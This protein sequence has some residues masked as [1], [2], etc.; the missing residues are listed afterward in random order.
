MDCSG[1]W[2]LS[3]WPRTRLRKSVTENLASYTKHCDAP[4]VASVP[5]ITFPL[6]EDDYDDSYNDCHGN[7]D[8]ED[9]VN[10]D[11]NIINNIDNDNNCR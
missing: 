3:T 11:N 5:L 4:E 6:P 8:E 2:C 9:D 10:N 1:L 7:D